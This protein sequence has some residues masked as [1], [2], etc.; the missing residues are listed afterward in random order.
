M[1]ENPADRFTTLTQPSGLTLDV[2]LAAVVAILTSPHTLAVELVLEHT[3]RP[4]TAA[5]DPDQPAAHLETLLDAW[6]SA[7]IA[8]SRTP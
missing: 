3:T 1:N 4:L 6:R 8:T 7:R 5:L 2:D